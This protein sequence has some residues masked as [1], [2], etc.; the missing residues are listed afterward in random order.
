MSIR[1]FHWQVQLAKIL[2]MLVIEKLVGIKRSTL[3]YS[4]RGGEN[5][6]FEAI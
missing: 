6:L 4:Y 3:Y 5:H 2:G 1:R